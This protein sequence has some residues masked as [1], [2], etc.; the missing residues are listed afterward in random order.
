L[1]RITIFG[2]EFCGNAYT[3]R[4]KNYKKVDII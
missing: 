2:I 4:Y 1:N 3:F